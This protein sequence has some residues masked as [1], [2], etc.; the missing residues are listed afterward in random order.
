[1]PDQGTIGLKKSLEDVEILALREY[2]RAHQ[3][4]DHLRLIHLGTFL[5]VLREFQDKM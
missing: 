4:N 5:T 3:N 1:M 2:E